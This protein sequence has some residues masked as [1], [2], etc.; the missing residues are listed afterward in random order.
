MP[1]VSMWKLNQEQSK[2]LHAQSLSSWIMMWWGF[3]LVRM[4]SA[5]FLD[6]DVEGE[7]TIAEMQSDAIIQTV[8]DIALIIAGIALIVLI[9]LM[10]KRLFMIEVEHRE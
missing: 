5:L 1:A 6:I 4:A 9:H 3:L 2:R 7:R 10:T 8:A